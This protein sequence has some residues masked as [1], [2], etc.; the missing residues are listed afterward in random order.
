M[1]KTMTWL[2]QQNIDR[3]SVL[4]HS[5]VQGFYFPLFQTDIRDSSYK[6]QRRFGTT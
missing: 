1:M 2:G 5:N 3:K 4:E 6:R